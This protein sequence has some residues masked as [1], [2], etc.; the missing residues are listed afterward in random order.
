MSAASSLGSV[1]AALCEV[2]HFVRWYI[3]FKVEIACDRTALG[4]YWPQHICY[5][6]YISYIRGY[7]H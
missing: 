2:Q 7:T 6:H 1:D 4:H 3:K 5:I